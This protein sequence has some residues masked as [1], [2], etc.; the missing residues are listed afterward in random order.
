MHQE[1]LD[2]ETEPGILIDPIYHV[3]TELGET[4]LM[5]KIA[6][7]L[8]LS[9]DEETQMRY[10]ELLAIYSDR[11]RIEQEKQRVYRMIDSG[12]REVLETRQ[13]ILLQAMNTSVYVPDRRRHE[14]TKYFEGMRHVLESSPQLNF[15]D[16][17]NQILD[18]SILLMYMTIPRTG[19]ASTERGFRNMIVSMTGVPQDITNEDDRDYLE[20]E[21]ETLQYLF[22]KFVQIV[23]GDEPL[24]V[25]PNEEI[26][27]LTEGMMD[28]NNAISQDG[29][30]TME[31]RQAR[32]AIFQQASSVKYTESWCAS[33]IYAILEVRKI[34]EKIH[35][36]GGRHGVGLQ[37]VR[38]KDVTEDS[39]MLDMSEEIANSL[40]HLFSFLSNKKKMMALA[41]TLNIYCHDFNKTKKSTAID[42]L[43]CI[44]NCYASKYHNIFEEGDVA[45]HRLQ[46]EV[47][48]AVAEEFVNDGFGMDGNQS[49][50][51][52]TVESQEYLDQHDMERDRCSA[53]TTRNTNQIW[54][55][56]EEV[57]E[58][59]IVQQEYLNRRD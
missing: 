50:D 36:I 35:G 58:E 54:R 34:F 20:E 28:E 27:D 24:P 13:N 51:Q 1:A 30:V 46:E 43:N 3:P 22:T 45:L 26:G 41:R 49:R 15:L 19:D 10:E 9:Y 32:I 8:I 33:I 47:V 29:G 6:S 44:L 17:P 16:H 31:V 56:R 4:L 59:N 55:E 5:H 53:M 21:C 37:P 7:Q 12:L 39:P 57:Q 52:L 42:V 14:L 11:T 18:G 25:D 48:D 2:L 38:E 40:T 23:A